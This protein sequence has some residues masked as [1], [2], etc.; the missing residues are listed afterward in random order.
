MSKHTPMSK[1]IPTPKYQDE[2]LSIGW[3][4]NQS[5]NGLFLIIA[6]AQMQEEIINIYKR[7]P[8]GIYNYQ[9]YP[10]SYSFQD[11]YRW[12]QTLSDIQTIF[13]A[14]LQYAIQSEEDLQHL[15]FSRDMLSALHKNIIFLTTP[16]GDTMLS[17]YAYDFYSYL[18]LQIYFT[19]Y[20]PENQMDIPS[21]SADNIDIPD[22]KLD[23]TEYKNALMESANLINQALRY[24]DNALYQN[25]LTLLLE[26][27]KIREPLLGTKHLEMSVLYIHLANTYQSLGLYGQAEAYFQKSKQIRTTLLGEAHPDTISCC[28][29]LASLYR[30]IGKYKDAKIF[31]EFF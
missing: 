23:N 18:K 24:K 29:N 31:P 9:T 11:L 25:C 22:N 19:N 2:Y 14:N 17:K 6:D 8:V 12:A 21:I 3:I 5:E 16:Y 20:L 27:Q 30:T 28:I 10:G 7:G 13:I 15:N 4:I 26:A 1:H